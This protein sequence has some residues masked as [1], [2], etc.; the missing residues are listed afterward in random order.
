MAMP[1]EDVLIVAV[2]VAVDVD[3]DDGGGAPLD[4]DGDGDGDGDG[5][6]VRDGVTEGLGDPLHDPK[7]NWHPAAQYRVVV[8]HH[9]AVCKQWPHQSR[10]ITRTMNVQLF[11]M[12]CRGELDGHAT[13]YG[14]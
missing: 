5:V 3:V 4:T 14:R 7:P 11:S 6:G 10:E 13:R 9:P 2:A 8:P 12:A 1:V